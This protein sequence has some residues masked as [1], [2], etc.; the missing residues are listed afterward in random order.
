MKSFIAYFFSCIVILTGCV[1]Q[2]DVVT[3][4]DRLA[5]L[6]RRNTV[7][8]EENADLESRL[9]KK[10][11]ELR[12]QVAGQHVMLDRFRDE[13]QILSGRVEETEH[14]AKQ[15]MTNLE[16]SEN[17]EEGKLEDSER[18]LERIKEVTS[19]NRDRI[20]RLEQY[21]NFEPTE[22]FAR[23]IPDD[24]V[25]RSLPEKEIYTLAKE[26]FDKGDFESGREGFQKLL[27]RYPDSENADN[28]QFWIGETYYREKWY[29]K[30]ILEYQK[31][32]EKYPEGNKVQSSLLKQGFAFKNLGDK[33]NASL[34]LKELVKKYP[35]ST[36]AGIARKKLQEFTP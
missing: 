19:L 7:L 20:L 23:K 12:N 18:E 21:L 25:E 26:A 29:E 17:R 4:D 27:K 28:A 24:Q 32:I 30:A 13:I 16:N 5:Q 36:E 14:L 33:A 2:K 8:E 22:Q 3:I 1:T 35:D 31:V 34:I 10:E 9:E 11:R 6:E 15:R